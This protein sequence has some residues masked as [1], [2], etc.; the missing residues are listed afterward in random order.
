MNEQ[1]GALAQLYDDLMYD[2]PYEDW[3]QYII[4][5]LCASGVEPGADLLEYACGTGNV[6]LPLAKAGYHVTA[7]DAS[8]EMLFCAQEKTR[9][10]ALRVNYVCEDMCRFRLNRPACAAV[11]ACD[12]VNYLLTDAELRRFF[13]QTYA[14]LQED[15][16]FLFDISSAYKLENILGNEF[17][18]DDGEDKTY[19]WQNRFDSE[20]KTVTMEL[21]FFTRQ[22]GDIYE[23]RDEIHVQRAWKSAEIEAML[24]DTGFANIKVHGFLTGD[25]PCAQEERIQF[26]AVKK[27]KNNE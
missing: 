19:F 5:Q 14:N 6:T 18:Y 1:Y 25:E 26:Q 22:D 9:K 3:S 24:C 13:E 15:G 21:T 16:I 2:A 20:R 23:R 8:E 7:V 11:C 17:Y 27:G 10:N 4:A 12:G